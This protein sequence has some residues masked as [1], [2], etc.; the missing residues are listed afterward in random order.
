MIKL[1]NILNESKSI[2]E[3]VS[4]S[5]IKKSIKKKERGGPYTII[6]RNGQK[7]VAH[8]PKSYDKVEDAIKMYHNLNKKHGR[9]S[10]VS[11]EDGY[12]RTVFM[13]SVN[14]GDYV[15]EG[16][17]TEEKRIVM[18]AVRKI[19][20]YMNRDLATALRYVIGTAKELESSGKVK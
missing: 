14:E 16:F 18:M 3:K 4:D 6:A 7:I 1:K 2:D 12:G 10:S 5:E 17:S 15:N 20:K 8:S 19:A 9:R 13:E 11:I